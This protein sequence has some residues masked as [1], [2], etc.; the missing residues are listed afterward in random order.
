[1]NIE[2]I[3]VTHPG[4]F[5]LAVF[6]KGESLTNMQPISSILIISQNFAVRVTQL[7]RMSVIR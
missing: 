7:F 4:I 1:M 5:S 2:S 3:F 6:F